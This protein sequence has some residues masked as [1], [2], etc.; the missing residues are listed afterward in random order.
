MRTILHE[1]AAFDSLDDAGIR[2]VEEAGTEVS[3]PVGAAILREGETGDAFFVVVSGAVDVI[4]AGFG[5]ED[6]G[7]K[8]ARLGP[9]SLFG[10]AAAM[11]GEP[12][13]ATVVVAE[14]LVALRFARADVLTALAGQPT[15]IA[16]LRRLAV[17]RAEDLMEQTRL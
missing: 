13:S 11:T 9:G 17:S 14:P 8:V 10:E 15:V 1:V 12:R 7:K 2:R 5:E 4:A 6:D 3:Y 16:E